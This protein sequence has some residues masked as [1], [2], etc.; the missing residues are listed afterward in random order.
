MS[1][2]KLDPVTGDLD[3]SS[4]GFEIVTGVDAIAQE[5]RIRAKQVQG[6]WWL[7]LSEGI[8]LFSRVLVNGPNEADVYSIYSNEFLA[9]D[10]V[11]KVQTLELQYP[12]PSSLTIAAEL[13][14]TEGVVSISEAAI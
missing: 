2:F 13:L 4:G 9:A 7:D 6:D 14:T 3:V 10:G 5:L 1:D 11:L 12:T 8:P